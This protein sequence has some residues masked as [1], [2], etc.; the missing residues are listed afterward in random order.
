MLYIT[1]GT[2]KGTIILTTTRKVSCKRNGHAATRCRAEAEVQQEFRGLEFRV[3]SLGFK[4]RG[5]GFRG[6]PGDLQRCATVGEEGSQKALCGA[7][8]SLLH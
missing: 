1:L 7:K 2:P 6:A 3:Q 5:L 4:V 8:P